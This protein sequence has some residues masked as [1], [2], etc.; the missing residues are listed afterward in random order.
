MRM[1]AA[2]ALIL[3]LPALAAADINRLR[4]SPDPDR[5]DAL[6]WNA[7]RTQLSPAPVGLPA[8]AGPSMPLVPNCRK[9]Q[10][11]GPCTVPEYVTR[12]QREPGCPNRASAPMLWP[13]APRTD[14]QKT[15]TEELRVARGW[16]QN[17]RPAN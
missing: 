11:A 14:E 5:P 13:K 2:V 12:C 1:L 7:R 9:S 10:I 8:W 4:L 17:S 6:L 16:V 15:A 3:A